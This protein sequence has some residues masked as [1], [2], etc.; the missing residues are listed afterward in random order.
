MNI[1]VEVYTRVAGWTKTTDD[2]LP[3]MVHGGLITAEQALDAVSRANNSTDNVVKSS[4]EVTTT[5]ENIGSSEDHGSGYS[6]EVHGM[7]GS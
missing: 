4:E 6:E 7:S 2:H 3:A 5:E 1:P